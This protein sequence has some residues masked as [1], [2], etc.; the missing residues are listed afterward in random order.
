MAQTLKTKIKNFIIFILGIYPGSGKSFS[1]ST[2]LP[3]PVIPTFP[4][5]LPFPVI[6]AI[7]PFPVFLSSGNYAF[8]GDSALSSDSGVFPPFPV[9]LESSQKVELPEIPDH[10]RL[11]LY[12]LT[13]Q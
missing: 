11:V 10:G 3:F 6:L 1:I 5:I 2:I 13:R 12:A 4:V 7:P 9:T 8:S